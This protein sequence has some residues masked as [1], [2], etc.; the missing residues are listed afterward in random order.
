MGTPPMA[1]DR[2]IAPVA[3]STRRS[4][5]IAK[6]DSGV[7]FSA[8]TE[9]NDPIVT[10]VKDQGQV[11]SSENKGLST[12]RIASVMAV[13]FVSSWLFNALT[14]QFKLYVHDANGQVDN[15][16]ITMVELLSCA[17]YGLLLLPL[18]GISVMPPK[19]LLWPL[20]KVGLA[21]L[22]ACRLF[23]MAVCGEDSIPISFAQTIRAANPLFTVGMMF[24]LTGKIFPMR[25]LVS[26]LPLLFGFGLAALSELSFTWIGFLAAVGSV[27]SLTLLN[28]VSKGVMSTGLQPHWAQMQLWSVMFAATFLAPSW[29]YNGCPQ[30]FMAAVLDGDQ[31]WNYVQLIMC[32]GIMYYLE[33]TAQFTALSDH[34]PLTVSVIDTVRRLS[35]VVISGYVIQGNPWSWSN[36]AGSVTV[37]AGAFYYNM[38]K[39]NPVK[40]D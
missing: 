20:A 40:E 5:R 17:T 28:V 33:Q 1:I 8:T 19:E 18:A 23:V 29:A 35:I 10:P 3:A 13:W 30:R 16:A 24:V 27:S 36:V 4:R 34:P 2:Q 39:E 25:V 14:P 6:L 15:E 7:V 26:L 31:G 37:M 21:H 32:N 38:V 22:L 9:C 11:R 12:V